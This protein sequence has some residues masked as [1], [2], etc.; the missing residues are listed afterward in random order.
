M[1]SMCALLR[2]VNA[3]NHSSRGLVLSRDGLLGVLGALRDGG[4]MYLLVLRDGGRFLAGDREATGSIHSDDGRCLIEDRA[5]G[6]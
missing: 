5:L 4:E 6:V 2:V 1:L 3:L